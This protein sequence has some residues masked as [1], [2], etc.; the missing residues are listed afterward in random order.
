[1]LIYQVLYQIILFI[2]LNSSVE[3]ISQVTS[4]DK[5]DHVI[6]F[7][8]SQVLIDTANPKMKSIEDRIYKADSL[9]PVSI[10]ADFSM[11]YMWIY[12]EN[13]D[14]FAAIEDS[15]FVVSLPE[16]IY[17]LA[18]G[19][20]PSNHQ[21]HILMKKNIIVNGE[22]HLILTDEELKFRI[23]YNLFRE[24]GQDLRINTIT[25]YLFNQINNTTLRLRY[26]GIDSTGF[27]LTHNNDWADFLGEWAVKGKQL[28]NE[29]N[30]YLLNGE[31]I[32]SD[33]DTVI[34][35]D[36]LSYAN[37]E[38][39]YHLPDS[40]ESQRDMLLF[41]FIP[42]AHSGTIHDPYYFHPMRQ[43]IF[44]DT[45]A[46][47]S[48]RSSKFSQGVY[49]VNVLHP[50]INTSEIR[51]Q[52]NAA[53]GMFYRDSIAPSFNL[54]M[55]NVVHIGLTPTFWFGKFHNDGDTI[56]I[57]SSYGLWE[58][59]FLSQSNDVL[60][61]YPIDYELYNDNK[62]VRAGQ[63][64]LRFGPAAIRFGFNP[65]D[66]TIPV[67]SG[68]YE[69]IIT[70]RFNEVAKYNGKSKVNAGF[71]L[72]EYDKNPPN[73]ILFQII[74]D[75][76]LTN[77]LHPRQEN[78][79]RFILE[80]N[81]GIDSVAIFY[82]QLDD[83]IYIELP[84]SYESPYWYTKIPSLLEGYYSLKLIVID[85]YKNYINLNIEPSFHYGLI[86]MINE[87]GKNSNQNQ[88]ILHPNYPNPFNNSTRISY[89]V[90][91]KF[92]GK[93]ELS[94]F[95]IIGQRVIKLNN[96]PQTQGH[97]SVKWDGKNKTGANLSSG[98]YILRLKGGDEIRT[99]KILLIN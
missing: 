99:K 83:S 57:N 82:S 45:S 17:N 50:F 3:N 89:T 35:N 4:Y 41:T 47:I 86:T 24:T 8:N 19:F 65:D 91:V 20:A 59:L 30:L 93:I 14:L 36:P 90:P 34:S 67:N 78:K 61:H 18:T 66:L 48:L 1:M 55:S 64:N 31:L 21:H 27:V 7:C 95:N 58:Q 72:N 49:V 70:D 94:V 6:D 28:A 32:T 77:I 46:D 42:D 60:R 16:G 85:E 80:D 62:I 53:I 2:L 54:S 39:N 96:L 79:I 69:M 23:V 75:N 74:S 40:I 5:V 52:N 38:F 81:E 84:L 51:I 71:D 11:A 88:L 56:R 98:I 25:F 26:P 29:N 33:V 63:F 76:E 22:T 92:S 73:V 10:S 37:S 9:Y 97:H 15:Q 13:Y 43:V 87:S 68:K 12:N 44:Q